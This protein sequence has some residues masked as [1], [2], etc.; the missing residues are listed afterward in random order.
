M[1]VCSGNACQKAL[2]WKSWARFCKVLK[3][4]IILVLACKQR[5][6]KKKPGHLFLLHCFFFFCYY[7]CIFPPMTVTVFSPLPFLYFPPC[8]INRQ[9]NIPERIHIDTQ[10][11][12]IGT[13]SKRGGESRTGSPSID[14]FQWTIQCLK[15]ALA[16]IQM[17]KL[18]TKIQCWL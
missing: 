17:E 10:F 14:C 12:L 9:L 1:F 11:S 5:I 7:F 4:W 2:M 6:K 3:Q 8:D 18:S 13:R 16:K 15:A